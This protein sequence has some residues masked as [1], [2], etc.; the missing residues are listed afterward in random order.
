MRHDVIIVRLA[1]DRLCPSPSIHNEVNRT[2]AAYFVA[3]PAKLYLPID[4]DF[5]EP[6]SPHVL[7]GG[8]L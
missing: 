2:A 7:E 5:R 1:A 6:A 3:T 4:L 8:T